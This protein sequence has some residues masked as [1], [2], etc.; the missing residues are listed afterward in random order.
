M[1]SDY[2]RVSSVGV[3]TVLDGSPEEDGDGEVLPRA[4]KPS[5][6][7]LTAPA[8]TSYLFISKRSLKR[9]KV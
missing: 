1:F 3:G 4:R 8:C 9:R 6:L 7:I 5:G 2:W